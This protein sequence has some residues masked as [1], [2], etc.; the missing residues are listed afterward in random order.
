MGVYLE[1]SKECRYEVFDD[2][3]ETNVSHGEYGYSVTNCRVHVENEIVC[4]ATIASVGGYQSRWS[5]I[6]FDVFTDT[7]HD[8]KRVIN[9]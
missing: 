5:S 9:V 3:G 1:G 6:E 8:M 4:T 2:D 7:L